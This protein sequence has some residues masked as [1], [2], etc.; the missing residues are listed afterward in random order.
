[1]CTS[2]TVSA[3][4]SAEFFRQNCASC[5][6]IGGGRLTGPDLKNVTE[7]RD[8]A[9]LTRYLPDPKAMIDAGD[10]TAVGLLQEARGVVMPTFPSMT[11][12]RVQELLE[13]ITAESKL[14]HSQF[15]GSPVSDRP[16]TSQD[17]A[18]G[19]AIFVG[20]Q[21]L[22]GGGPPCVSCHA[23]GGLGPL[24]GGRLGPDLTLVMERLQGRKG[25]SAWLGAPATST[26]Q[27]V[28]QNAALQP[29]EILSVVAF[30][31]DAARTERPADSVGQLNFFLLGLG[32]A[33]FGLVLAD[34]VWKK[35][36]RAV[37]WPLVHG[38]ATGVKR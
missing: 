22:K 30:L 25:L 5:H 29:D 32:A 6:T 8:H 35:R 28:F 34:A 20:A 3:Q 13:F 10:P 14:A 12:A 9:W 31:D 23:T 33:V 2:S 11:P 15:A 1:M 27:S 16:F 4:T 17:V 19:R 37:R 7:R 26:M 24:G 36:F 38:A 21:R 18:S